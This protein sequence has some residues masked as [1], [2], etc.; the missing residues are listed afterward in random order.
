MQVTRAQSITAVMHDGHSVWDLLHET[1]GKLYVPGCGTNHYTSSVMKQR[2][3][4]FQRSLIY[5][6]NKLLSNGQT[7]TVTAQVLVADHSAGRRIL[8]Y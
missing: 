8:D 1:S 6:G 5:P 2:W 7:V 4:Q 3:P